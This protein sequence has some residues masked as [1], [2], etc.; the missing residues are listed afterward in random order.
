MYS[1]LLYKEWIKIR[2]VLLIVSGISL[3]TLIQLFLT[4]RELFEFMDPMN[5]WI[6]AVHRKSVFYSGLKY[7]AL[8]AGLGIALIQFVPET[9]KRRLRLLFHLPVSHNRSLYF[10]MGAGLA[11]TLFVIAL[12]V[13]GLLVVIAP[14]YP[15]ELV[16]SAMATTAPWFFAGIAAYF[17]TALVIVEPLWWRRFLYA[18]LSFGVVYLFLGGRGYETY[19]HSFWKY[20]LLG[21]LFV[22]TIVLPAFRFKR[23]IN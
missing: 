4:V 14:R 10:M 2:W 8:L 23:G 12:N 5:V 6:D 1:A 15:A 13:T 7:N 20:V 16:W 9:V 3:W 11:C 22:L 19:A 21:S 18:V 17:A